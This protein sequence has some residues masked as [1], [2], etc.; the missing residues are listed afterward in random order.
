MRLVGAEILKLRKRRGLMLWC[1]ILA[2]GSIVFTEGLLVILHAASPDRHGSAGGAHNL[3]NIM[4]LLATLG[5]VAGIIIGTTAGSQDTSAGVFRDLVVTGR[6][7][8]SLFYA[9]PL[10]A[11]AVYLPLLATGFA[12]AVG[13]S[14]AFAGDK[15]TSSAHDVAGYAA[16]LFSYGAVSLILGVGLASVIPSRVAVGVLVAWNSAV[17]QIL[18]NINALGSAR[19]AINVAASFHFAPNASD[20]ANLHMSAATAVLVLVAWV[21]VALAV[22]REWTVRRDA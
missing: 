8:R 15:T 2:V 1:A 3:D 22:G 17:A 6:P 11:L 16:A 12:I 19:D 13:S 7:R 14:Y 10:G 5:G 21:A 18:M 4:F 9:R 20:S